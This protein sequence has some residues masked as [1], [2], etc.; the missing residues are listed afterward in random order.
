[1][2]GTTVI[3]AMKSTGVPVTDAAN[4]VT[5]PRVDALAAVEAALAAGLANF[6]GDI[7]PYGNATSAIDNGP[8]IAGDDGTVP[9]SDTVEDSADPDDDNDGLPDADELSPTA[10]TPFDL[11]TTT[12]PNPARGDNTNLDGDGPSWDTDGDGVLDGVEC[13]LGTNPRDAG[14]KPTAA[15]C[16]GTMTD[17]DND[18]LSARAERCKWGTSDTSTDSDGDGRSDCV[19]ANDTNGDGAQNFPGDTINSAKAAFS[20]IVGT[21]DFDLN[22]DGVVNFPSD[23]IFSAKM[24]FGV[25][26]IVC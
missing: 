22:G 11:S 4:G 10:C 9:N 23:T 18:G 26:P 6:D 3:D 8:G 24:A 17:A 13:D 20:L 1:M 2:P 12:H 7:L 16:G 21:M 15:Q 14:S 19:E 5:T 25:A